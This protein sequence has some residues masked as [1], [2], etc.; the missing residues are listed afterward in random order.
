MICTVF[1]LLVHTHT[2]TH[3][4]HFEYDSPFWH[5]QKHICTSSSLKVRLENRKELALQ[6]KSNVEYF[7]SSREGIP[8]VQ[9]AF[10]ILFHPPKSKKVDPCRILLS[11]FHQSIPN[12]TRQLQKR[13]W[14]QTSATEKQRK[15]ILADLRIFFWF[16]F[17]LDS[18][19]KNCVAQDWAAMW[20]WFKT[21]SPGH[22]PCCARS[23]DSAISWCFFI[24]QLGNKGPLLHPQLPHNRALS[25]HCQR[26]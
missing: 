25:S 24:L 17:Y 16:F 18:V 6:P 11:P 4:H 10:V 3:T 7:R 13:K 22:I 14:F 23:K 21:H 26:T 5:D 20:P 19:F 15:P 12:I 1:I 9:A 8:N 2:H